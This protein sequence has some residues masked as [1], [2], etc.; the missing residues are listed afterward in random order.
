MLTFDVSEVPVPLYAKTSCW[1]KINV[2]FQGRTFQAQSLKWK[3][4]DL[5]SG[6]LLVDWISLSP[7]YPTAEIPPLEIIGNGKTEIK[8]LTA[9]AVWDN[10]ALGVNGW[11][12]NAIFDF[13]I[14]SLY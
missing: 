14:L 6:D 7:T 5:R 10:T 13:K 9:S 2:E 3:L 11:S 12:D 4:I 1:I 8:R